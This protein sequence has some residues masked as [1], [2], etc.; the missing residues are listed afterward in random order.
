M[1]AQ[2]FAVRLA[3]VGIGVFEVRPGII[4]SDMSAAAASKYDKLMETGLVPACRW[5]E[6]ADVA[7]AVRLLAKAEMAFA[8]GSVINVDGGL[9]V[10][11]L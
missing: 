3:A 1:V 9:T 4:R 5:G 11:R 2:G 7:A 8:T 6:G 10:S